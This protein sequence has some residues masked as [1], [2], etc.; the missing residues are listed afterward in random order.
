[1]PAPRA[2][3]GLLASLHCVSGSNIVQV[4][5]APPS[6]THT[7]L[8]ASVLRPDAAAAPSPGHARRHQRIHKARVCS[9]AG[10]VVLCHCGCTGGGDPWGAQG[11]WGSCID[12]GRGPYNPAQ[13]SPPGLTTIRR[14]RHSHINAGRALLLLRPAEQHVV[15]WAPAA[16]I[17]W[18]QRTRRC[19]AW[20][21]FCA[22]QYSSHGTD[23]GSMAPPAL[24]GAR[25]LVRSRILASSVDACGSNHQ[26]GGHLGVPKRLEGRLIWLMRGCGPG[27]SPL[28]GHYAR[29]CPSTH[30]AVDSIAMPAVNAQA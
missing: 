30:A 24:R 26:I 14:K 1:M 21:C 25:C 11:D 23:V 22:S 19:S 9:A 12:P 4:Q 8:S 15:N 6:A 27:P 7:L 13:Q 10:D 3:R 5:H 28:S 2:A 18:R 16:P 29:Q 17:S 20:D